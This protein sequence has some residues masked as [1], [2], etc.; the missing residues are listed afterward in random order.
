M[1]I[2]YDGVQHFN[3]DSDLNVDYESPRLEDRARDTN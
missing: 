1:N 2:E 3:N